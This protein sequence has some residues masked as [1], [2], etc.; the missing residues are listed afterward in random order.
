M[1]LGFLQTLKTLGVTYDYTTTTSTSS[2]SSGAS[3]AVSLVLF[4]LLF[5][6]VVLMIASMWKVFQK[7]GRPGW[8]AIVPIYNGWVMLEIGG[9]PGWIVLLGL[10]PFVGGLIVVIFQLIATL[11]I[12]RRFGK[13]GAWSFFLLFFPLPFI[14]WPKLAFSDATYTNPAAGGDV[15]GAAPPATPTPATNPLPP[16]TP[17][18]PEPTPPAPGPGVPPTAPPVPP[19]GDQTPPQPPTVSGPT[20]G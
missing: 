8:A 9:Q 19:A 4:A 17:Q 10:I 13:G 7:A 1:P 12:G 15:T 18:T 16:T 20:V 6:F 3:S 5:V 2:G 11:E 14:G